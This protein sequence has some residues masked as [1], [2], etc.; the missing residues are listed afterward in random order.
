M[1]V[2]IILVPAVKIRS[3]E[4]EPVVVEKQHAFFGK[5]G[6]FL[7]AVPNPF[8]KTWYPSQGFLLIVLQIATT[9]EEFVFILDSQDTFLGGLLALRQKNSPDIGHL[10]RTVRFAFLWGCQDAKKVL[11]PSLEV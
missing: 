8:K 6:G 2:G 10:R 3:F 7:Q 5:N 9:T 4:L 11:S 1:E